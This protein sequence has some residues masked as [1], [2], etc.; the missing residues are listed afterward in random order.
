MVHCVAL[1]SCRFLGL[2]L[3]RTFIKGASAGDTTA[4]EN[5]NREC[6]SYSL[7]GV[8]SAASFRE[9]YDVINTGGSETYLALEWLET[10]LAQLKYL[11]NPRT[12]AIIEKCLKAALE[13]CVILGSH[14]YVNT[15]I[16][17][18]VL[19]SERLLISLDYKPANTLLSG[20]ETGL[21]T[22]KVGDLGLGEQALRDDTDTGTLLLTRS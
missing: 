2:T 6:Q 10:T 18:P 22:V 20:V 3:S 5:L 13:T 15:G 7:P 17:H 9:M 1:I 4:M 8:A 21:V 19:K 14:K 16:W 12:Y 11:P